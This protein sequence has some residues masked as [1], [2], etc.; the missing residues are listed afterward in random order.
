MALSICFD[1][2][3]LVVGC[4]LCCW[5]WVVLLVVDCIVVDTEPGAPGKLLLNL[6]KPSTTVYRYAV[7]ISTFYRLGATP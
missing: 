4:G 1:V 6:V 5:L 2:V 3:L 7:T